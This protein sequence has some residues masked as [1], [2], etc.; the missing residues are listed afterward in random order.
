MRTISLTRL[1]F[2]LALSIL[3]TACGG[4]N[5]KIGST[6]KGTRIAVMEKSTEVKAD[7]AEGDSRPQLPEMDYNRDWPQSGHNVTHMMPHAHLSGEPGIV[8]KTNIGD[9]SDGDFKL[10]APPVVQDGV[11]YTMDAQGVV[12][13]LSDKE[14]DV[15][16]HFDTTPEDSDDNAIGGGLAVD[17]NTLYAANGFGEILALSAKDGAVLWRKS[18]L[19]P[20]RAAPTIAD[21]RVYAVTIDNQ[22]SALDAKTGAILWQHRGIAESATLMG[23][24][25]PA[26]EGDNVVVAYSSGEIYC[27]RAENGRVLWN[28][29]L[30]TPTQV[31]ALPAIAD[32]RGLPVLDHGRVYA[33]SHNGRIASVDLRTGDRDWEADVGSIHTPVVTPGW[34]FVLNNERQLV[35]IDRDNGRIAWV[36]DMQKL[37]DPTDQKSDPLVWTGPVVAGEHLWLVSSAGQ[38]A[39]FKSTDGS[40]ESSVDLGEAAYI[41]PIVASGT[42]YVLGDEGDLFAL[43]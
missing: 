4:T 42:M 9:G 13:A 33:I 14:G 43:R 39:S 17:A 10:L 7:K 20:V 21:G 34:V 29:A 2:V 38:L 12:T 36:K 35:A 22:L 8:W 18:L 30:T 19:V 26:V 1:L 37:T 23:A 31:G 32:I 3:L 11:V 15:L 24:A 25:S 28:Y 40:E 5:A 27:L 16:W 41:T 6:V